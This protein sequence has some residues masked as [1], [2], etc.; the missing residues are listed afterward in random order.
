MNKKAYEVNF[1]GLVGPTHNYSGLSFGNIASEINKES[2]SNPKAAALQGLEKMKLLSE[3]GLK[4]AVIPPQERPSIEFLKSKGYSGSDREILKNATAEDLYT[5]SSA[6]CMW[7]ANAATISP[8]SDTQDNKVHITP[9]NL[10]SKE[11][12]KIE[13]PSTSKT[14]KKI[15][16]DPKYFVHHEPLHD[17]EAYGDEGAANHTRFCNDYGDPGLELFVYGRYAFDKN[18]PHPTKFP[19]RQSY[20]ASHKIFENHKLLFEKTIFAQ[21]NP[22]AIDQGVFHNDVISVGNSNCFLYHEEAF[23]NTE[24]VIEE[25]KNKFDQIQFIKIH[26]QDLSIKEAVDSYLFNSQIVNLKDGMALIAPGECEENSRVKELIDQIISENNP[27]KE[28]HYLDLRQ[29]MRNGGGPACLRLRVVLTEEE[30]AA[31]NQG[32]IFTEELYRKL[33]AWIN[34]HYRDELKLSD[35]RDPSLL[36]ES[37]EAHMKLLEILNLNE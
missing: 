11:H 18:K 22:E 4:Q 12:R 37:R 31:I 25:I 29:S 7:T 24:H 23:L 20:E 30:L 26:S 14:L 5:A 21:Q 6:S 8:S 16:K 1:D 36:F 35:L 34:K 28:V 2:S 17:D 10:I 15:F 9:A 32:V 3:M 19:A 33:K 27:I 13:S